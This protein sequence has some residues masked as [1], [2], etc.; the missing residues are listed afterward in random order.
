M[1]LQSG[2]TNR[3]WIWIQKRDL[4]MAKFSLVKSTNKINTMMSIVGNNI[5]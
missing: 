3:R 5:S 2:L 4:H 1:E